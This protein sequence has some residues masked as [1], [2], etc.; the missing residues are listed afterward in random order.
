MKDERKFLHMRF[1][2]VKIFLV[3]SLFLACTGFLDAKIHQVLPFSK[4]KSPSSN[5]RSVMVHQEADQLEYDDKTKVMH[6][7]GHVKLTQAENTL[8][9]DEATYYLTTEEAEAQGNLKLTRPDTVLTGNHLHLYYRQHR[10]V[11]DGNVSLLHTPEKKKVETKSGEEEVVTQAP[12]RINADRLEYRWEEKITI[13]DGNVSL[14]QGD[15]K[16]YADHGVY[17][18]PGDKLDMSGHVRLLRPPKD[19]LECDHLVYALK[20]NKAVAE[21]HVQGHF[22]LQEKSSKGKKSSESEVEPTPTAPPVQPE[23][24]PLRVPSTP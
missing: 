20:T 15:R 24:P 4:S 9:A 7:R 17:D 13:A 16:A 14:I 22:W 3:L 21:G 23:P 11:F 12:M 10:A 6:L 5:E 1:H 18:E 8:Y 2:G 19:E